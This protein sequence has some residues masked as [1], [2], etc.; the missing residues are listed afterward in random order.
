MDYWQPF[1]GCAAA[2][3]AVQSSMK[4]SYRTPTTGQAEDFELVLSLP[5][6]WAQRWFDRQ[7]QSRQIG[8][9]TA[10]KKMIRWRHSRQLI[11]TEGFDHFRTTPTV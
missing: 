5:E 2:V 10:E 3:S 4:S 7:P 1:K 6:A 11:D 9:I 8:W